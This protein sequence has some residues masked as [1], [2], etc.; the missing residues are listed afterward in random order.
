MSSSRT[1]PLS[2]NHFHSLTLAWIWQKFEK[3]AVVW[4]QKQIQTIRTATFKKLRHGQRVL[5]LC[6]Y[7]YL[8][9]LL[10]LSRLMSQKSHDKSPFS[11]KLVSH[12]FTFTSPYF[13]RTKI[14]CLSN[15][16]LRNI[17][18]SKEERHEVTNKA[19]FL[20]CKTNAF[21]ALRRGKKIT[22][23]FIGNFLIYSFFFT[24]S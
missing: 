18:N 5:N 12:F 16:L 3:V 11:P 7:Y 13:V 21:F 14:I 20:S 10:N 23:T 9:T 22:P 8:T 1:I 2:V 4:H 15:I 24:P 17:L 19:H 6:Y